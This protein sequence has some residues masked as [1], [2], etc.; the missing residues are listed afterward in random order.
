MLNAVL[1]ASMIAGQIGPLTPPA[2]LPRE[3][4][5]VWVA[6]VANIDWPSKP[7]LSNDDLRIEMVRIL[8]RAQ[9][10]HLNAIVFQV[11]PSADAMYPSKLEPWSWFLTGTQ[12]KGLERNFDPLQ[13]TIEESHRR[14]IE[15][16]VWLNPYRVLHPM[17]HGPVCDTH[18]SVT[19]PEVVKKY[20]P[21]LWMD[22]SEKE[23]QDHS[24]DVFMDLVDRYDID[25]IHVDDYFYPYSVKDA[26]NKKVPFPDDPSW[27]KYLASGG[28]LDRDNW[29][30]QSVD[31]FIERVY[32]GVKRRKRWVKFG[33]SPFG[34]Y[35][36]GIPQGIKAG[37]DQYAELYADALKWYR[38]G[39][40]DY[41][42][43]QLYW[44]IAQKPQSYPIL[45]K[46]WQEQNK[47]GRHLWVGNF[48]SRLNPKDGNWKPKEVL[49]QIELSR[50]GQSDPGNIH[51]SMEAFSQNWNGINEALENGPYKLPALVPASPWLDEGEIPTLPDRISNTVVGG[52]WA[53]TWGTANPGTRFFVTTFMKDKKI[54]GRKVSSEPGFVLAGYQPGTV[55]WVAVQDRTGRLSAPICL[56]H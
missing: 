29:R 5:A 10:L 55:A 14:G 8:D 56:T 9:K 38:D 37:V 41:L 12:G 50:K 43:P 26:N 13:F 22:P 46:Y 53:V 47:L 39:L 16:H 20:G 15:L 17:Q 1:F 40:C 11:R 52:E 32:K 30:R 33:I 24:F 42:A 18:L 21:Y 7:G 31:L 36:P 2:S 44:P 49:D 54:I 48:T 3:F 6:T 27:Q 23:V 45:L 34:I 51:F 25:G 19:H 35:R 4:R 28:R